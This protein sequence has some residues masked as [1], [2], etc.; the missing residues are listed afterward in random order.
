[1]A[2]V[3]GRWMCIHGTDFLD[4]QLPIFLTLYLGPLY[5]GHAGSV[6]REPRLM[7][8]CTCRSP[9]LIC[10]HI[11][12]NR[13]RASLP[14]LPSYTVHSFTY[15]QNSAIHIQGTRHGRM[16]LMEMSLLGRGHAEDL[17]LIFLIQLNMGKAR[18]RS[19]VAHVHPPFRQLGAEHDSASLLLSG[20]F[21]K[22]LTLASVCTLPR[23]KVDS[24]G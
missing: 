13:W 16:I 1:M 21:H 6:D 20:S 14:C 15:K 5:T 4:I 22:S 7:I 10:I 12:A 19:T 2:P 11:P 18:V 8:K 23:H 3:Q 17:R 9:L 24:K